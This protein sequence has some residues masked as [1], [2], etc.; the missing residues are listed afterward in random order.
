MFL[1]WRQKRKLVQK[2]KPSKRCWVPFLARYL[3]LHSSVYKIIVK[4]GND[5]SVAEAIDQ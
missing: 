1:Q 3:I 4:G 5:L 2:G